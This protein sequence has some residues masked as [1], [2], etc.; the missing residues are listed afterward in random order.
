[1]YVLKRLYKHIGYALDMLISLIGKI[2]SQIR[3]KIQ[4]PITQAVKKDMSLWILESLIEGCTASFATHIIFGWPF[5]IQYVLAH[6]IIIKQGL[7]II[8]R[9]QDG[10][11]KQILEHQNK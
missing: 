9:I 4:H 2:K 10:R 5:N 7:S 8:N 6:G 11:P 1:M 3:L